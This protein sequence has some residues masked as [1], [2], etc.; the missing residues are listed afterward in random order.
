MAEENRLKLLQI[1]TERQLSIIRCQLSDQKP[2]NQQEQ[3]IL[4][5]FFSF[6]SLLFCLVFL[7]YFFACVFKFFFLRRDDDP[8]IK[9]DSCFYSKVIFSLKFFRK[10][11]QTISLLFFATLWDT[12][13]KLPMS[14]LSP[15]QPQTSQ[16]PSRRASARAPHSCSRVYRRFSEE[17]T[18]KVSF[19]CSKWKKAC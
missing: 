5:P 7:F 4:P 15:P 6:P 14:C 10:K 17:S 12:V 9:S 8:H 3:G 16:P 19:C 2:S 11:N 18:R 13:Q 1:E